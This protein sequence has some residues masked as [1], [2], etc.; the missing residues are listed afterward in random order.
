MNGC[1]YRQTRRAAPLRQPSQHAS[2]LTIAVGT[3]E[4]ALGCL[5]LAFPNTSGG[6]VYPD[7]LRRLSRAGTFFV[8]GGIFTLLSIAARSRRAGVVPVALTLVG[9]LPL[10]VVVVSTA[11]SGVW[12]GLIV[13]AVLALAVFADATRPAATGPGVGRRLP[14]LTVVM[15][16]I[17]L[18]FGILTLGA[19][20]LLHASS[21]R[22]ILGHQS[23]FGVSMIAAS[24]LLVLGWLV[25]RFRVATQFAAALPFWGLASGFAAV[26]GWSGVVLYGLLGIFL[27]AEPV[28]C[29]LLER[30]TTERRRQSRRASAYEFATEAVAWGFALLVALVASIDAVPERRLGQAILALCTSVFTMIWYHFLPFGNTGPRHTL[31]AT[32][33]YSLLGVSLVQLTDGARSPYFFVYFLPIIALAWTQTPHTI[34]VPLSIPLAALLAEIALGLGSGAIAAGSVLFIAVP[35]V[36]GLLLIAG[37]TY[38]LARRN[39]ENSRRV[40][41]AHRQLEAVLTHTGAGLVTTDPEGRVVLCN[42]AALDLAGRTREAV[43]GHLL[44]EILPLRQADGTTLDQAAHPLRQALAGHRARLARFMVDG[45]R[46]ALP[47]AVEAIPLAGPD[48]ARGAIVTLRDIRAEAEIERLRDDFF[49]IASH[50]LRTPLTIM[51]GNLELALDA[52]PAPA[53]RRAIE[54]ALGSTTRLIRM[55]NDFLDAARLEHGAVSL[56]LEDE[57]LPALVQQAVET[58]RPDADRKGLTLTYRAP[59]GLPVVRMDVERT[60]QILLNLIGNSVRCT[61]RGGIDITHAVDGLTVETIVQD[62]GIGIAP[63]HHGRLFARFGQVE[64]GLTR[65][66]G[67]SGLGLYISRKLAEQMGGTVVLK[68][69]APGQGSAFALRL[70]VAG[71][72]AAVR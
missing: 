19:P 25:P 35:R 69:S 18:A 1:S 12:T 37:F 21:Y 4:L 15:A 56:R 67:G 58:L 16:V 64:R 38:L 2:I 22:V 32:A 36:A 47:V 66:T 8:A 42:P 20:Q 30:R 50:E 72:P 60:L 6:P 24:A 10:L 44:T 55:V 3:F 40:R 57:H 34:V 61:Q 63:E 11:R 71:V 59:Q 23:L 43:Q 54:E 14:T 46:G 26:R 29:T 45:P 5:L 51:R 13:N 7:M 70:P 28:L 49:F 31:I 52:S 65:A 9:V 53:L 39:L 48:G 41:D 62:S 27:A 68:A 17:A 33:V